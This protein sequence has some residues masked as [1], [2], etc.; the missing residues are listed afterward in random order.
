MVVANCILVNATKPALEGSEVKLR[1]QKYVEGLLNNE[2]PR[3]PIENGLL[4]EG[5]VDIFNENEA[6]EQL[7]NIGLD[8]ATESDDLPIEDVKILA[9]QN[10]RCVW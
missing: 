4:T 6:S 9:K 7:G 5:P 8:K 10:I 1:W 2:N 3:K